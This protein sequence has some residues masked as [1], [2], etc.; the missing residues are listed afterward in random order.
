MSRSFSVFVGTNRP[1]SIAVDKIKTLFGSYDITISQK[2]LFG[3]GRSLNEAF[4]TQA[5][6]QAKPDTHLIYISDLVISYADQEQI[7]KFIDF[8]A[9]LDHDWDVIYLHKYLDQCFNYFRP[10]NKFWRLDSFHLVQTKAAR[11]LFALILSPRLIS[12]LQSKVHASSIEIYI[13][14]LVSRGKINALAT[15]PNL[16]NYDTAN[17]KVGNDLLYNNECIL[18]LKPV[19]RR[20]NLRPIIWLI[21]IIIII[22]IMIAIIY[23]ALGR[24]RLKHPV[25]PALPRYQS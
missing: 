18:D 9:S 23:Y 22:A 6:I 17:A 1:S 12:L 10:V 25:K 13:R 7:N 2:E 20:Q 16:F 11:G 24:H 14:Y 4:L 5:I 8:V 15:T 19:P 3:L 21:C